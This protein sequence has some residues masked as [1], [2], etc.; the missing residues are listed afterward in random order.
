MIEFVNDYAKLAIDPDALT[1][2]HDLRDDVNYGLQPAKPFA[3]IWLD[4]TE[5]A[6]TTASAVDDGVSLR[7]GESGVRAV[8]RVTARPH[9]FIAEVVR[10]EG[11]PD[12]LVFADVR[13]RPAAAEKAGFAGCALALNLQTNVLELP[14]SNTRLRAICYPRFGFVGAKAAII[15]CPR[16]QLRTVMQEVVTDAP[17]LPKSPMGGPW[18]LD[19]PKTRGSYLFNF[20]DCTE[21]TV[22]QWIDLARKLGFTQVDF[23]GGQSFRFGDCEPDPKMYPNGRRSLKAVVD[24]LHDA[25]I[26]AGFHFYSFLLDKASTWVTP[27]PDK[28]LGTDAAFTLAGP[29]D[30]AADVVPVAE[31][32]ENMSAVTGFFV[33]NSNTVW[34]D[35]EL[36]TYTGVSKEPPYAFTGCTRGAWGTK[37]AAHAAGAPVRHLREVFGLF[38]P[39]GDSCDRSG[40]PLLTEVADRIAATFNECGFDMMYLDALDSEDVLGGWENGW[41]YGSK[42]VFELWKRLKKPALMEMS[43]FHHHLWCVRS[44]MGAWDHPTRGHKRFI[45]NHV[46]ANRLNDRMF[47]PSE[48]GWWAILQWSGHDRE[49]TY[50]DDVAYL[51]CKCI[52]T[53]TGF[54]LMGIEPSTLAGNPGMARLA[55]VIRRHETLRLAGTVPDAVKAELAKTNQEFELVDAGEQPRFRPVHRF[56]RTVDMNAKETW[57]W[58]VR[59]EFAPQPLRM[60]IQGLRAADVGKE[61][62]TIPLADFQRPQEFEPVA[63][64]PGVDAS[65]Q[66]ASSRRDVGFTA[67]YYTAMN[68]DAKATA[69]W[70]AIRKKFDPPIDLSKHQAISIYVYGDGQGEVLNVQ[71]RSPIAISTAI[72][73]HYIPITFTG[74]RRFVLIEPEAELYQAFQWPEPEMPWDSPV[75]AREVADAGQHWNYGRYEVFRETIDYGKVDTLSLMLNN[76]ARGSRATCYIGKIEAIPLLDAKI[77]TPSI[78]VNKTRVVFPVDVEPGQYLE[79][80]GGGEAIVYDRTGGEIARVK[81][82]GQIPRMITGENQLSFVCAVDLEVMPRARVMVSVAGECF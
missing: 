45:D 46:E 59:N 51:C 79:F 77:M 37:A 66:A 80:E 52:G 64:A 43:T 74:W 5:Y 2:F 48:L 38:A 68:K 28:Q 22:G 30:A 55:E 39:D 60:R 63:N 8:V 75:K 73:D 41:H 13:L 76:I 72:A 65:F 7:F 36:I 67:C 82:R 29:L 23:H 40:R 24:K 20:R 10:V 31:S 4:G 16:E 58:T 6:A 34:I 32:T 49:P 69:A 61:S 56:K 1:E 78:A 54:A 35:D 50:P 53:D 44:R 19:E 70:S 25:G 27:V 14:Q 26:S 15:G 3:R 47:L 81:P 17:D 18:A 57:E 33:R 11:K 71:L 42:F 62:S 12:E 21:Q 9:Y